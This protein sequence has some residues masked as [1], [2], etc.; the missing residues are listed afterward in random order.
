MMKGSHKMGRI[1]HGM[2]GGQTGADPER[3]EHAMKRMEVV[4]CEAGPGD[5]L[6]FH[7]NTLHCSGPNH[8]DRSRWSLICC[9]N[10]A[11]NDPYKKHHHPN[12]TPLKKVDDSAIKATGMKPAKNDSFLNPEAD[13]TIKAETEEAGAR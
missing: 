10:A 7:G 13:Q 6:F 12:Y 4:Y 11:W 9:Y 5:A 3:V 1:E 8:S 2:F